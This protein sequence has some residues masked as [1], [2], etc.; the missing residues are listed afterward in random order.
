MLSSEITKANSL[1]PPKMEGTRVDAIR[2]RLYDAILI[3]KHGGVLVDI[4]PNNI[5]DGIQS[6]FITVAL[7]VLHSSFLYGRE[8]LI[9]QNYVYHIGQYCLC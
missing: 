2:Y 8:G 7:N 4:E 9:V 5:T 6:T 3:A 1:P